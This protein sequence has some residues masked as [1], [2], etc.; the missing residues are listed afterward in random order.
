MEQLGEFSQ[1]FR[2]VGFLG[3]LAALAYFFFKIRQQQAHCKA[4][5]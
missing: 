4:Y 3:I 2:V 5:F 1:I